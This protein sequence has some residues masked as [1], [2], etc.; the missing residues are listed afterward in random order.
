MPE[1]I[2]E[3]IGFLQIIKLFRGADEAPRNKAPLGKMAEEHVI[4]HQPGH[5]HH[6]PAGQVEQPR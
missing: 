4:G 5:R 2:V 1:N 6:L 3:D